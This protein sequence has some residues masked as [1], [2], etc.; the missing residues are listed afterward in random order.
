M[1]VSLKSAIAVLPRTPSRLSFSRY[2]RPRRHVEDDDVVVGPTSG[3]SHEI[4][5]GLVKTHAPTNTIA[6][7]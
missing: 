3:G 4:E 7:A 1:A 2:D 6:L 5:S